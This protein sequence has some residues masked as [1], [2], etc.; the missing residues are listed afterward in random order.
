MGPFETINNK[1]D[2]TFNIR[3]LEVSQI[4]MSAWANF[5]KYGNPNGASRAHHVGWPKYDDKC[6]NI[7][8]TNDAVALSE[9]DTNFLPVFYPKKL[10]KNSK[11]DFTKLSTPTT[12]VQNDEYNEIQTTTPTEIQKSST[13]TTENPNKTGSKIQESRSTTTEYPNK[14]VVTKSNNDQSKNGQSTIE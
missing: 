4:M 8:N 5:V 6:P 13:S 7:P 3:D 14:I 10:R 11:E 1:S 9:D 12:N 2:H